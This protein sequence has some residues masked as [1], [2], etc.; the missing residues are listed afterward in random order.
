MAPY[1]EDYNKAAGTNHQPE[2]EKPVLDSATPT[3]IVM[4]TLIGILFLVLLGWGI[5]IVFA[6]YTKAPPIGGAFVF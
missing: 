1:S 5:L 2:E 3:A 6:P 4:A